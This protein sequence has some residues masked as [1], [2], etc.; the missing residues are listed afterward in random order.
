[1]HRLLG[2]CHPLDPVTLEPQAVPETLTDQVCNSNHAAGTY[3]CGEGYVCLNGN[4]EAAYVSSPS[5][6][7]LKLLRPPC[8]LRQL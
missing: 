5:V 2:R 7:N 1:M 3:N 4:Y 6:M 8:A